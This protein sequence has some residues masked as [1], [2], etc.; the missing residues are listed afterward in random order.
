MVRHLDHKGT[1]VAG[2]KLG[3]Q[4]W[5]QELQQLLHGGRSLLLLLLLVVLAHLVLVLCL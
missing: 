1:L 5:G 3:S 4:G 2:F